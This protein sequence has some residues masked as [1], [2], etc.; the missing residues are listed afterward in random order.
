M[1]LP[2]FLVL[3]YAPISFLVISIADV[4]PKSRLPYSF[5]NVSSKDRVFVQVIIVSFES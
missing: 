2:K 4:S 5:R 3:T 1:S